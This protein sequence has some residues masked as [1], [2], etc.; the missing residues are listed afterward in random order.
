M[1]KT[2]AKKVSKKTTK[3]VSRMV[4]PSK[5]KVEFSNTEKAQINTSQSIFDSFN[6]FIFSDDTKVLGKLVART[7]LAERTR[8]IPG[9]IVEVGVFKGSGMLTWLKMK[10]ILFPNSMKKVLGFDFFDTK[11]LIGSLSGIDKLRMSELFSDRNFE[12]TKDALSM[13]DTQIRNAGYTAADYELIPG[14]IHKTAKEFNEKRPGFKISIL[15][16]DLDIEEP[17]Y[18]ALEAFWD[19][20]SRGGLVV[21]DEYAYHQWSESKAVDR[22]FADKKVEIKILDFMCPT[23]YIVK[24]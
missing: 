18:A 5:K 8:H 17:T 13:I 15:Y 23:A 4:E 2:T 20:V 22:F 3:K 19:R 21:F 16:L 11:S 6:S 24:E 9:D 10:K 7:L 12:H 1:K 14:D